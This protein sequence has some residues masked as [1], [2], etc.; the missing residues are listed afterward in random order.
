M[1][2]ILILSFRGA[3]GTFFEVERDIFA[4]GAGKSM[5]EN[6]APST[7]RIKKINC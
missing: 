5:A 7:S 6:V 2:I 1:I 4:G 3:A